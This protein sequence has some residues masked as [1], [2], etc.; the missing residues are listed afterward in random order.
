MFTRDFHTAKFKGNSVFFLLELLAIFHMVS[1]PHS[2]NCF[3]WNFGTPMGL[4]L[5]G[6]SQQS[7]VPGPVPRTPS[8]YS[9]CSYS[10]VDLILSC[11]LQHSLY[12]WCSNLLLSQNLSLKLYMRIDVGGCLYM[13]RIWGFS[14][15]KSDNSLKLNM[16]SPKLLTLPYLL[17]SQALPFQSM[18]SVSFHCWPETFGVPFCSLFFHS[19]IPCLVSICCLLYLQSVSQ[20]Y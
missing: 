20:I 15:W 13:H 14:S 6:C 17:L 12:R 1:L 19:Q 10:L 5:T 18:A 11:I 7:H 4:L 2:W 16:P 8:L 3:H 9:I